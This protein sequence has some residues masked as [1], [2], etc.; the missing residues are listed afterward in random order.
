MMKTMR[1]NGRGSFHDLHNG[2]FN[3]RF[4]E[5]SSNWRVSDDRNWRGEEFTYPLGEQSTI[6][7]PEVDAVSLEIK[8]GGRGARIVGANDFDGAAV[9]RAILLDDNDSVVGLLAG[10]NARQTDHQHLGNPLKE[11]ELFGRR[12]TRHQPSAAGP[13]F[14]QPNI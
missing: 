6:A 5:W 13:R 8:R 1:L 14:T 12:V 3:D 11:N 2:R 4:G 7:D 10:A 9:A